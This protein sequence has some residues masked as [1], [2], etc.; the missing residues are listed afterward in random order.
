MKNL[1]VTLLLFLTL[2]HFVSANEGDFVDV[3]D[4]HSHHE[5][6]HALVQEGAINGYI[7]DEGV[8]EFRPS[9]FITRA[10]SA[11]LFVRVFNFAVPDNKEELLK[12]YDDVS[13][14]N[15]YANEI[16]T[17]YKE[18]IF[19]GSAGM[20]NDGYLTREQMATVIIRAFNLEDSGVESNVYTDNVSPSHKESVEIL[21]QHGITNQLDDFRPKEYVTRGQFSTFLYNSMNVETDTEA[22][23]DDN[24]S[25][26]TATDSDD[27]ASND[28]ATD[29]DDSTSNDTATDSD[30]STSNDTA[31]DSDDIPFDELKVTFGYLYDDINSMVSYLVSLGVDLSDSQIRDAIHHVKDTK[32]RVDIDKYT[33]YY[34]DQPYREWA[35]S[36]IVQW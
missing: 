8:K 3:P 15:Y 31:T 25:G 35:N 6:I 7:S 11:A 1:I 32:E 29:S 36:L 30:D 34:S 17:A 21:A 4:N 12:N 18:G 2:P 9:N 13:T 16:A 10:Q 22:D 19:K 28:T 23:T 20:F 33:F 24:T 5:S 27:S 26:D 14:D